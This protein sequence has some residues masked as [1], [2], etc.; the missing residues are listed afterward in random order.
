M[1]FVIKKTKS[2]TWPVVLKT[3]KDGGEY[4]EQ[5]ITLEFKNL[6]QSEMVDLLKQSSNDVEFCKSVVVGWKDVVSESNNIVEFSDSAFA[7]LLDN[8]KFAS[9][10]MSQYLKIIENVVEKN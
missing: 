6:K 8:V 7:E 2:F 4:D 5:K 1:S 3:P 10:I 9:S